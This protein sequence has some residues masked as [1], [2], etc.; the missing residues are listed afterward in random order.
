MIAWLTVRSCLKLRRDSSFHPPCVSIVSVTYV[1][2]LLPQ[3]FIKP[4]QTSKWVDS[5]NSAL[6]SLACCIYE[7]IFP[8]A[9]FSRLHDKKRGFGQ[10]ARHGRGGERR[11][12]MKPLRLSSEKGQDIKITF[13]RF[14]IVITLTLSINPLIRFHGF[15]ANVHKAFDGTEALNRHWTEMYHYNYTC[16]RCWERW[17]G[18]REIFAVWPRGVRETRS[19]PGWTLCRGLL[20]RGWWTSPRRRKG[21]LSSR[22]YGVSFYKE[23][24]APP[25]VN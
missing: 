17:I 23:V 11:L 3:S 6:I 14:T 22:P 9:P 12:E 18:A 7:I 1:I 21:R 24:E 10:T 4:R 2:C 20:A 19:R 15:T 16:R 8:S 13:R 25:R 5:R